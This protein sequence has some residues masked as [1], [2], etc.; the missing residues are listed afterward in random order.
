M[1]LHVT[2]VS[3][4]ARVQMSLSHHLHPYFVY[5]SSEG[6]GMSAHIHIVTGL[7]T[8]LV[9]NSLSSELAVFY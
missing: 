9:C 1:P 6:Y 5:V 2:E 4:T 3:C 7:P 8:R